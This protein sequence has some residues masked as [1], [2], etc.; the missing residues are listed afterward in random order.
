MN[1]RT[2][3]IPDHPAEVD[4]TNRILRGVRF[5]TNGIASDG[6]I[7][8]PDGLRTDIFERAPEILA[9]HGMAKTDVRPV[10]IARGLQ[11]NMT[12]RY[13][14]VDVQF[15]DNELGRDYAYLYGVN[16]QREVFARGWS[17]GWDGSRVEVWGLAKVQKYLGPDYDA[18]LVPPAV[19]RARSV[20]VVTGAVLV[21]ISATPKRAD[22]NALTRAYRESGIREAGNIAHELQLE[23]ALGLVAELQE[24]H[25][26]DRTRIAALEREMAALRDEAPS[27]VTLGDGEGLLRELEAL[28]EQVKK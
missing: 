13:G 24:Q 8:K 15:A 3:I 11:L 5:V 27:S 6:M 4:V 7:V 23:E 16:E 22:L 28:L 9:R 10:N 20:P 21:E 19:L 2:V 26:T 14:E 25:E 18:D 1:Q 17:F 12:E